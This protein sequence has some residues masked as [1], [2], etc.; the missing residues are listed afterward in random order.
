[1]RRRPRRRSSE[2]GDPRVAKLCEVGANR[3]FVTHDRDVTRS[4]GAFAIE[5]R[6]VRGQ[7]SVHLKRFVR[8]FSRS[9]GIMRNR[10]G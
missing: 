9:V 4:G 7:R 5:H 10:D 2:V 3:G 1:V 8:D 6:T